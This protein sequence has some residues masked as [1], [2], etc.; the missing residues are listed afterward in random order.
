METTL[1]LYFRS[2]YYAYRRNNRF[3][4]PKPESCTQP[5]AHGFAEAPSG[6]QQPYC[7]DTDCWAA[8]HSSI[9]CL[10][11]SHCNYKNISL[12]VSS[13]CL[14]WA[15]LFWVFL[16][17]SFALEM[18]ASPQNLLTKVG[19]ETGLIQL[20]KRLQCCKRS[21]TVKTRKTQCFSLVRINS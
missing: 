12:W 6:D 4:L 2:A 14:A 18:S 15:S 5:R 16:V 7:A 10:R 11:D 13:G 3:C 19:T 17:H 8:S 21:T 1:N 20:A 9:S